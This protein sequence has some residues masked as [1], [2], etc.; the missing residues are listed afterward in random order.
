MVY[1]HKVV[2]GIRQRTV[3]CCRG[4]SRRRVG[5]VITVV[6]SR[7]NIELALESAMKRSRDGEVERLGTTAVYGTASHYHDSWEY[8]LK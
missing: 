5:K 6:L 7:R 4:L 1:P 2:S 3:E 8:G